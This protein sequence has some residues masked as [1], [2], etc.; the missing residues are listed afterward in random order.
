M[1]YYQQKNRDMDK[2]LRTLRPKIK[3]EG[4]IRLTVDTPATEKV[5]HTPPEI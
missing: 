4:F 1:Y 5:E 3:V 2:L